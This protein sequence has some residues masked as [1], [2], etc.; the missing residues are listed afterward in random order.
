MMIHPFDRE[1]FINSPMTIQSI[2][3]SSDLGPLE[4]ERQTIRPPERSLVIS[5]C[6]MDY[7]VRELVWRL[8]RAEDQIGQLSLEVRRLKE[9]KN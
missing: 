1:E 7:D 4:Y 3:K 6:G 8:L 9:G 5:I 2:C